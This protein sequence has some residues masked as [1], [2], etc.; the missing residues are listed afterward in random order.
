MDNVETDTID[1]I[2]ELFEQNN[3]MYWKIDAVHGILIQSTLA[4]LSHS[5]QAGLF[6]LFNFFDKFCSSCL[7]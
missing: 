5:T 1:D 4:L 6:Q 2:D 3:N 7:P